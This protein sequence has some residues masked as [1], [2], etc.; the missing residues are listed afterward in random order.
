[1]AK[2]RRLQRVMTIVLIMAL[3]GACAGEPAAPTLQ[4][5]V[6][7]TSLPP[8]SGSGGGRIAFATNRDG[9]YEI[10]VMNADG[11]DQRRLTNSPYEDRHPIWSPDG[12]QIV[13]ATV[14]LGRTEIYVINADGSQRRR[15]TT[16]GGGG[17]VWSPDGARIAYPRYEPAS[18]IWVMNADGSDPQP[19]TQTG[20]TAAVFGPDWSPDGSQ[21]VCAVNTNP[22]QQFD[23]LTTIRLLDV[24]AVAREGPAS[25][26]HLPLLA[27]VGERVNDKPA[28]SPLGME[29]A[30]STVVEDHRRV[31]VVS[32]DGSNLRRLIPEGD[33]DAFAPNWSPDGKQITF[34]YS[35]DQQWD[36]Y[37]MNA[38]GTDLRRLTT[39]EANDTEPAW[40][41]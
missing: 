37:I 8:L 41:P 35:P 26:D 30:F 27:Q 9:N 22:L 17:P 28:W 18:D 40:A 19:L 7:P 29:I 16:S 12:S 32:A 36:I 23:E 33:A 31:Y 39:H 11:S 21:I 6:T 34:Q 15:L 38:D 13:Y 14:L 24:E 3:N 1:M 4:P 10:Y 2:T 25:L 5:T 20:N